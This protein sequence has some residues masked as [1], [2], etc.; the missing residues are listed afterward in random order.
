MT[1]KIE[2]RAYT[3]TVAKELTDIKDGILL[4]S[5]KYWERTIR[6]KSDMHVD[7]ALEVLTHEIIHGFIEAKG[8]SHTFKKEE[9]ICDV[10]GSL[11]LHL[12]DI[13]AVK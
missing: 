9:L 12:I 6:L 3:I 8:L 2:G 4:G 13:P 11:A 7:A 1:I 10:F 5:I